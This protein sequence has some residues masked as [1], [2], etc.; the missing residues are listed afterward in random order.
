MKT[1]IKLILISAIIALSSLPME[2]QTF[3]QQDF[4][5]T[6]TEFKLPSDW[7][8]KL[9][10]YSEDSLMKIKSNLLIH[11]AKDYRE[12][13]DTTNPEMIDCLIKLIKL[14]QELIRRVDIEINK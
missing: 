11:L 9:E 7:M 1:K 3:K 13:A 6:L 12:L 14:K 10:S 8:D 2:A 5:I 4:P